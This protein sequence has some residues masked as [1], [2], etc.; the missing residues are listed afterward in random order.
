MPSEANDRSSAKLRTNYHMH[1]RF[2]DGQGEIE[3]YVKAA[4]ALDFT[5]IG[6]SSHAPIPYANTYALRE[7]ALDEYV[8]EVRR[9]QAAYADQIEIAL[10][11]EIDVIP[12]NQA[13]YRRLLTPKGFDYFVCLLGLTLRLVI[14]GS[15][16][17]AL[18]ILPL[19]GVRSMGKMPGRWLKSFM[20]ERARFLTISLVS[21]SLDIWIVSSGLI[22]MIGIFGKMHPG[23]VMPLKKLFKFSPR[24]TLL[25]N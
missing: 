7:E 5:S 20:P 13:Y 23:I 25:S 21:L 8:A 9:L 24:R 18:R 15:L 1:S 11:S 22:M 4:I 2:C 12:G 10:G 17:L 14:L 3:D 19:G 16:T 6:V